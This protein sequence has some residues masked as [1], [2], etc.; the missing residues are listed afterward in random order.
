MRAA[1]APP[2]PRAHFPKLSSSPSYSSPSPSVGP[3]A[4]PSG[5]IASA[6]SDADEESEAGEVHDEPSTSVSNFRR[7]SS[8]QG[9]FVPSLPRPTDG[10]LVECARCLSRR[11]SPPPPPP[12]PRSS[13]G[14]SKSPPKRYR[15]ARD[16]TSQLLARRADATSRSFV[17]ALGRVLYHVAMSSVLL[18]YVVYYYNTHHH[19]LS[20]SPCTHSKSETNVLSCVYISWRSNVFLHAVFFP[21]QFCGNRQKSALLM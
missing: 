7:G 16:E 21:K 19:S 10:S 13:F 2:P 3:P 15:D 1:A 12:P 20:H 6:S 17:L 9:S 8:A 18:L 14:V 11:K 4:R 5:L